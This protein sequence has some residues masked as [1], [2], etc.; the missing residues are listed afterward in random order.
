[1]IQEPT[2]SRGS[3]RHVSTLPLA[4]YS[5]ETLKVAL[6]SMGERA[7]RS[8]QI[9]EWAYGKGVDSWDRMTNLS[10][11]LRR[12]LESEIPLY[13][14][15]VVRRQASTDG[16]V[17]LL[18]EWPD[19]ATSECVLIPDDQRRTVCISSQVGCPVGC[20]FCASGLGGLQRQLKPHEVVEQVMRARQLLPDDERITNVVFMGLGEPLAN[21]AT[22]VSSIRVLNS[23]WG[24]HIGARRITVS[25]VGLPGGI[26]KLA[27]EGLQI[28]LAISLH[29]PNDELRRQI[30]PWSD[31]VD[32][33][34]LIDAGRDY[35]QQTG[36]EVTLEYILLGGCNDQESH[37][38]ELAT[39][40]RRLRSNINLIRYNEVEG[41][42]FQR[43]TAESAQRFMEILRGRG[44]NVH[45]RRSRGR[46]ID[47]ACGQ[48]RRRNES[49]TAGS[50]VVS[51]S[52]DSGPI[53]LGVRGSGDPG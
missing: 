21:Y 12:R 25:T 35:F 47:A 10:T 29:A 16:T 18:L 1:M 11:D 49:S 39:V 14:S 23:E 45:L 22:T 3:D 38:K 26:R 17:K 30:I 20:L 37:A 52:S 4:A 15:R 8:G 2:S 13:A 33:E 42:P 32:I 41:L 19:G 50:G 48:L 24:P 53:Q 46:D 6:V 44:I 43:P 36:R 27:R 34:Q 31:S 51:A 5:E 28:T 40:A 9:L 7:F